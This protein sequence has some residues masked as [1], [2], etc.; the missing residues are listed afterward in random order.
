MGGEPAGGRW[1]E[2]GFRQDLACG[3]C[4]AVDVAVRSKLFV[5]ER[6]GKGFH[7]GMT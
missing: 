1:G 3:W 6:G 4:V 2:R 7:G 5:E